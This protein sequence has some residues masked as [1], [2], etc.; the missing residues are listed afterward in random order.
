MVHVSLF[1]WKGDLA[2]GK[3]TP[4]KLIS[5]AATILNDLSRSTIRPSLHPSQI[6]IQI[7]LIG[8]FEMHISRLRM[9]YDAPKTTLKQPPVRNTKRRLKR[10]KW[11]CLVF[12]IT[13]AFSQLRR[14]Q[15]YENDQIVQKL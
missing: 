15:L 1:P 11:Y 12:L 2:K 9:R 6:L 10:I 7:A 13:A 8:P 14:K 4:V 3:E 5:L